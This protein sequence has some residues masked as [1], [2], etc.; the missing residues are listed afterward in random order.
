MTYLD[1]AI[2]AIKAL[3][4]RTGSSASAIK[5]YI[6]ANNKSVKFQ[7][8]N[9]R[10][11]LK[12]GVESGMLT[13]VKASY[14]LSDKAKKPPKKKAAPKKVRFFSLKYFPYFIISN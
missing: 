7:Q 1:M 6:E 4:D 13:P 8:H 9:L 2:V 11:A 10:A 3:K 12:K 5:K 14:K